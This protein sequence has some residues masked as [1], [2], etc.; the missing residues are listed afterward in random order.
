MTGSF[1]LLL[2]PFFKDK[3]KNVVAEEEEMIKSNQVTLTVTVNPDQ[4]NTYK[5]VSCYSESA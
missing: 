3:K 1:T 5:D 4:S 2:I